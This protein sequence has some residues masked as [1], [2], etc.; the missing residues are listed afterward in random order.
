[1]SPV[2]TDHFQCCGTFRFFILLL[3]GRFSFHRTKKTKYAY[4]K[5]YKLFSSYH[6]S[7]GLNHRT[8]NHT[9]TTVCLAYDF[10]AQRHVKTGLSGASVS[11]E[12]KKQLGLAGHF[13]DAETVF[14]HSS[15]WRR[16][17]FRCKL[18]SNRDPR[19]QTLLS[20][21]TEQNKADSIGQTVL[22]SNNW[23]KTPKHK[24]TNNPTTDQ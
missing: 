15:C 3:I 23:H 16:Q 11:E 19:L 20:S 13:E 1:M 24:R 17:R 2:S 21:H 8:N 6:V 14:G 9:N 18:R 22:Q 12:R 7:S 4:L 10:L 5:F